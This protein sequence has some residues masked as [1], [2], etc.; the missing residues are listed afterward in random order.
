MQAGYL[1][2]N[3]FTNL[4]EIESYNTRRWNKIICNSITKEKWKLIEKESFENGLQILTYD[5]KK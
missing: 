3:W 1:I 4:V 5:W 2:I